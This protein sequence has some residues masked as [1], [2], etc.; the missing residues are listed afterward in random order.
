[1]EKDQ[2]KVYDAYRNKYRNYLLGKIDKDGLE[3]SKLY[4]LE[5]LMKLRQICDSPAIL[6]DEE[7]YGSQSVKINELIRNIREKTGQH[8]IVVF[9]QFVSMLK[10]IEIRLKDESIQYEYLDGKSTKKA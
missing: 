10:L 5:G 1:M 8:K 7:H 4:V 9:S 6:S 2:R 3:K